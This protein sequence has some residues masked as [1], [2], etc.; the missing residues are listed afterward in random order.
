M[1]IQKSE[2]PQQLLSAQMPM[3]STHYKSEA[4]VGFMHQFGGK[5]KKKKKDFLISKGH[6]KGVRS[7]MVFLNK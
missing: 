4:S 6:T 7:S 3:K 5:K 1:C 2:I